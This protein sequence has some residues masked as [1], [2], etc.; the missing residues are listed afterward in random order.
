M[1]R[2]DLEQ[3]NSIPYFTTE[4][5]KQLWSES[6]VE[7]ATVRTALS[8]WMKAGQVISLKKG[9]YMPRRFVEL[10][11]GD[12][13]FSAA[14]S[15]ILLPQSYMSL[16]FVL[17]RHAILTEVTYPVS[18]VTTLNTRVI[19][20]GLGTFTYRHVKI[21]LFSGFAIAEYHGIRF[22]MA[23]VAKALFDYL[24]LRPWGG[25]VRA[26]TNLA[27]ELRLNLDELSTAD[28]DEFAGYVDDTGLTKMKRILSNLR[29]TTWRH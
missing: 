26:S 17:Q 24:Y 6:N 11:R 28:R 25:T 13:D 4:S 16:E 19:E 23:S 1:N 15:A 21:D 14:V 20:N 8:R 10:H 2:S 12:A 29:N 27:E 9:V 3:L 18:A 5:I 7:D 22:A